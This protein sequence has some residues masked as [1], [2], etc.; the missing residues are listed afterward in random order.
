MP[1]L[2]I[3][4]EP[5]HDLVLMMVATARLLALRFDRA[6]IPDEDLVNLDNAAVRSERSKI[7]G[8][9]GLADAMRKEPRRAV[10]CTSNTR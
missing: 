7:A 6:V 5:C 1:R 4:N 3:E 9:H 2:K 8:T 10:H